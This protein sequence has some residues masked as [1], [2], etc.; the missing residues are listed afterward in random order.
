MQEGQP[1]GRE[2]LEK[3]L[4]QK[5][6]L[7][8]NLP[9]N[10]RFLVNCKDF[11]AAIAVKC[12]EYEIAESIVKDSPDVL[13][14][15]LVKG[16]D[17]LNTTGVAFILRNVTFLARALTYQGKYEEADQIWRKALSVSTSNLGH[18]DPLTVQIVSYFG[19]YLAQ[20]HLDEDA[21]RMYA[22][23]DERLSPYMLERQPEEQPQY[24]L[25]TKEQAI[26]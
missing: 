19:D 21:M 1:S 7:E 4:A 12:E 16:S 23:V 13:E 11:F 2:I 22:S 8:K 10:E 9:D 18:H 24:V 6:L 25:A 14:E 17:E 15:W 20:R 5:A 3:Y 26:K